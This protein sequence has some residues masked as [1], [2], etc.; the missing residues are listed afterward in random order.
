MNNANIDLLYAVVMRRKSEYADLLNQL[1]II[2]LSDKQRE[3]LRDVIS[4]EFIEYGLR[5]DDEPNEKG[6]ELELL[7]DLLGCL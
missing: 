4:D 3:L 6:L 7:I 1:G 5:E 2:P